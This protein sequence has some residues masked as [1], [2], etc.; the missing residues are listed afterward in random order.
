VIPFNA[1]QTAQ[2]RSAATYTDAPNPKIAKHLGVHLGAVDAAIGGCLLDT[3]PRGKLV[4]EHK[5]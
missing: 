3:Q 1:D 2:R 5:L 4:H